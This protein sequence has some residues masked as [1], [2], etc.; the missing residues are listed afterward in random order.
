[1]TATVPTDRRVEPE[2]ITPRK[3]WLLLTAA[4]LALAVGFGSM[5]GG[6]FGAWYTWDQRLPKTLSH[7]TTR[8]YRRL[9]CGARHHVGPGRHNHAPPAG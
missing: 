3:N 4:I 9:R 7:Q 2:T 6:T 5:I 8:S 1:M